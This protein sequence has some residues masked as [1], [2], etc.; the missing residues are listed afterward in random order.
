M[1]LLRNPN[2]EGQGPNWAVEPCDDDNGDGDDDVLYEF[3][4]GRIMT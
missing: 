2:R 3:N 4:K 1:L